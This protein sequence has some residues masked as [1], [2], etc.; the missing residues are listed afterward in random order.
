[1]GIASEILVTVDVY[2]DDFKVTYTK[3]K[4]IQTDDYYPFGL[5]FNS[6]QRENSTPNQY[7]YNG[8]EIQDELNLGWYDYLARQYDPSIGRFLSVDPAA[9]VVR[10][11][12]TY[13]YAADNP[14]RFIDPD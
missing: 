6:Y 13:S 1:M 7:L 11:W 9:D 14:I 8:K 10:R 3:Q 12:S 2:F 4:V 5:T